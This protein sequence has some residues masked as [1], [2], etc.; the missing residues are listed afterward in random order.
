MYRNMITTLVDWSEQEQKE[1]LLLKGAKGV[2]KT[3][4]VMDFAEAFFKKAIHIDFSKDTV[5]REMFLMGNRPEFIDEQLELLTE[6]DLH[7]EDTSGILMVYDGVQVAE[8]LFAGVMQYA[9]QRRKLATIIIADWVGVLPAENLVAEEISVYTMY[10]MSFDEFLMA[11]KAQ[12]LCRMIEKE[13]TDGLAQ[14]L[15]PIILDYLKNFYI[16]GGMPAVVL[17]FIKQKN[18]NTVDEIQHHILHEM[19]DEIL[20][21]APKTMVKKILQVWDSI[22]K[23]LTKENK[24]FM[25]GVVDAKARAREYVGAVDWLVNAG[26]V[27]KVQKISKGV[28]PLEEYVEPKSFEL[29]YLDHG[30]LRNISGITAAEADADQQIFSMMNGIM[31]EQIVLSELTLNQN[32]NELYFWTSEA[33]AKVDFVFE[34]DG[35]IIP[36]DVQ[37]NI[38]TKAQ[39]LKVFHQK[40]NNRMTIRISLESL[41]FYKG[42]LNIPLYGLWNF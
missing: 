5:L 39:N 18:M 12:E 10:P 2:G 27:R 29:Y 20:K 38:R 17:D 1:I 31:S 33:T 28:S 30:L 24:K 35:E 3:W 11:N 23:Q 26:Y 37:T 8:D 4:C 32:V 14:D 36:V 41:S 25:Y 15:R 13:K 9:R 21:Y 40:Y 22:P 19:R 16:I 34:D 42:K 7:A 6:T